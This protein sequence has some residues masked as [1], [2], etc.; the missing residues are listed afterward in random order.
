MDGNTAL[1]IWLGKQELGQREP[2]RQPATEVASDFS[3]EQVQAGA[4]ATLSDYLTKA[5]AE[6]QSLADVAKLIEENRHRLGALSQ[7]TQTAD[8]DPTV[9][10][11]CHRI[12]H[13]L[14]T[15]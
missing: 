11:I 4:L 15:F 3:V 5:I 6:G 10:M 9:D 7:K 12:N 1:L 13:S 14:Q 2:E 8:G